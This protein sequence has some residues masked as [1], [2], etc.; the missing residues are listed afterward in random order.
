VLAYNIPERT[1]NELAPETARSIA[2]RSDRLVGLKDSSGDL[3]R[4]RRLWL[5]TG[6][7]SARSISSW[8]AFT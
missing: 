8:D 3:E 4:V 5:S 6:G 1:G 2:E 7:G